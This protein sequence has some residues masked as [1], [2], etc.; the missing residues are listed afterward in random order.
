[1]LS[2]AN[3]VPLRVAKKAGVKKIIAHSHNSSTPGILRNA[4][5]HMNK[6]KIEKYATDY[7]AC[8]EV[9]A[10]WLFPE[11]ICLQ[12]KVQ[13]IHNAILL[14]RFLFCE[15]DKAKICE[16]L[17]LQHAWVFG[18]VGRF[19]EQKNH[20]FLLDIFKEIS[21]RNSEAVLLL[22]GEGERMQA[23][24]DRVK[25][26]ELGEKV[27]FLGL[28][29]D[30]DKLLKSIDIFLFPSLFEGLPVVAIEAQAAG[31][32]MVLADT[33]TSEVQVTDSLLFLSLQQIPSQW[34]EEVCK[35][36][37][38][39]KTKNNNAQIV[40]AFEQAGYTIE[41]AAEKLFILYNN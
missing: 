28:R 1:M 21:R 20:M 17:N 40:T 25:E 14:E 13:I 38:H 23:V 10:Q 33:I 9:A 19:E 2:A 34:A 36:K 15:E 12:N 22:V 35:L 11:S 32:Y 27:R 24:K 16:E 4:L 8:S 37:N 39:K 31:V 26:L 6:G 18:H 5:H 41:T 30:V 7:F 3:I 29:T